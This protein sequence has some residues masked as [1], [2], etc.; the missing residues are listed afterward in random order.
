MPEQHAR[1]LLA[2][3]LDWHRRERKARSWEFFRLRDLAADELFDER[4]GLSGLIFDGAAGGTAR[5]PVDRYS[6]PPQENEFRGGEE[7]CEVGGRKLGLVYAIAIEEGWIEIKNGWTA[8]MFT[9][10]LFFRKK[11]ECRM[12]S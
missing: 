6:F 11:R 3:S 9:P 2:N 4:A 1:W 12:L 5:A 10:K 7:L 8:L